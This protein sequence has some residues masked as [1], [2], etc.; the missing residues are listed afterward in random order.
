MDRDLIIQKGIEIPAA[1][2]EITTSRAGG[3]G[4]QHVNKTSS[5]VSLRWNLERSKALPPWLR[6]R[7][8]RRLRS[9]L[10]RDGAL[11][12]HVDDERSQHRNRELARERLA[13][14]VREGIR[15]RKRRI[16]TEVPRAVRERRVEEK[17]RRGARKRE[18]RRP[19]EDE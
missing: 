3:P 13:E 6:A 19:T 18:R 16:Q 11:I 10:T 8:M 14:L 17:R 12:V 4:G 1:E 7:A 9:R 2:L 15:P 5:R